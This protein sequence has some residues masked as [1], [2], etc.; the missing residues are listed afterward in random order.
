MLYGKYTIEPK[1]EMQKEALAIADEIL[2]SLKDKNLPV[3]IVCYALELAIEKTHL[4]FH[5]DSL[6]RSRT[7]RTDSRMGREDPFG[8]TAQDEIPLSNAQKISVL[9][10][11]LERSR[12]NWRKTFFEMI[13]QI[14]HPSLNPQ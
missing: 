10:L 8:C 13:E 6:S 12:S 5:R 4:D 14:N 2:D 9:T 7:A 11:A 1:P 3:G